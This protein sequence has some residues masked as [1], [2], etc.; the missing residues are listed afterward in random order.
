MK[1]GRFA[2]LIHTIMTL[3]KKKIYTVLYTHDDDGD[4]LYRYNI[5]PFHACTF[6]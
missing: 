4:G 5:E 6:I 1:M 3:I 2:L